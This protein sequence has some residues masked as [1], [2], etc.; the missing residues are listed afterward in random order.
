MEDNH[1]LIYK[2]QGYDELSKLVREL[3][4]QLQ[5]F[6]YYEVD[7]GLYDMVGDGIITQTMNM[8]TK[9]IEDCHTLREVTLLHNILLDQ[10]K[11]LAD[12]ISSLHNVLKEKQE[13]LKKK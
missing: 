4:D 12:E 5:I 11:P 2:Y 8:Y 9:Y 10:L 13:E 6:S 3:T 7:N 1:L